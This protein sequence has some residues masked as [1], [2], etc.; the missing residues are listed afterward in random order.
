MLRISRT[1]KISEMSAANP[2][3]ASCE[4]GD[5]VVFETNDCFDGSV[6]PD[7]VR[8]W[9]GKKAGKYMGNPATGPL[10][11]KG[12]EPG[13]VLC[14]EILDIQVRSWGAMGCGFGE[15]GFARIS[16]DGGDNADSD[17]SANGSDTSE[18]AGG[19][20]D[21]DT[22]ADSGK[23]GTPI[24]NQTRAFHYEDGFVKIGGKRIPIQPMIGVI[25]VAPA[26]EGISTYVPDSH[27]GN[28]DCNRIVAGAKIL[29]PVSVS[30]ALL[31]MGD[32]H[33]LMGDG[34]VFQYGLETAGEVTVR[35]SVIKKATAAPDTSAMPAASAI[36]AAMPI[37]FP[38]LYQGGRVMVIA[39]AKSYD[40]AVRLSIESMFELLISNGWDRTEAGMLM[41]M[42]CDLAICQTVDPNVTVRAMIDEDLVVRAASHE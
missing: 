17:I 4:S 25:G 8:D 9:A 28:M 26:G 23:T 6:G 29:L 27:G 31:A 41:S 7:G 40:D 3:V 32:L 38:I 5:T 24:K 30:G 1:K 10:F 15:A 35:V 36:Q 33:A 34:E 22:S 42:K 37:K 20:A 21:C 12:A 11:V 19:A 16:A 18:T 39:S 14:V 13:D 2:P